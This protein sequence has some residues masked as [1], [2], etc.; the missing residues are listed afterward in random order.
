V[1]LRLLLSESLRSLTANLSTTVAAT[2]TVLIGMFL[3]GLFVA[4]GSW[5]VSWSNHVKKEVIVKVYFA[6]D[7]IDAQIRSVNT[8]LDSE[9]RFVKH[10]D[11]V[12]KEEALARMQKR[13]PQLVKN[14]A[15]NPLPPSLE[16]TPTH[17]EFADD[18]E[19]S[20]IPHPPGVDRINYGKKTANRIISVATVIEIVFI[21]A[22]IILL[23]AS[24]LLIANTIRLSIFARRRE[25][26]VMKLVGATN[27][28]VRGPF[29]LEGLL[30][31][32]VGALAAVVLLLLG[33]EIAMPAIL[34]HFTT[35]DDVQALSFWLN[36]VILLLVFEV[37]PILYG[38]YIS[39]CDWRLQCTQFVGLDNYTRALTDSALWHALLVTATYALI[40]VPLQLGLGLWIAYMLY[41]KVRGQE[42][43]RQRDAGLRHRFFVLDTGHGGTQQPDAGASLACEQLLQVAQC[44]LGRRRGFRRF[45]QLLQ[46]D[47]QH[48]RRR[49]AQKQ[50]EVGGVLVLQSVR[51]HF[52]PFADLVAERQ[53]PAR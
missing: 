23:I 51:R 22:V 32:F 5:V 34:G 16:V 27:W 42:V 47:S 29:M 31:G 35:S 25:I 21:S 6:P 41:Q 46:G 45:L 30:C 8:T 49:G 10:V 43:F 37:F 20:L 4:L 48:R 28:F 19:R 36:A 18:I 12:S 9:P 53:P 39:A 14:L 3:L 7:S 52:D 13:Y 33:K 15:G 40:S 26:E 2:M 1:R 50:E 17:A 24:T 44:C 11:Y 38:A